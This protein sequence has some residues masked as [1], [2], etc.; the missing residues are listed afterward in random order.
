MGQPC[1]L[2]AVDIADLRATL[3][4]LTAKTADAGADGAAKVKFTGLAQTAWVNFRSLS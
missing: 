2:Q 4:E 1:G 3:S